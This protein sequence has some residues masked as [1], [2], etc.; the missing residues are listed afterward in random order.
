MSIV[1]PANEYVP[2]ALMFC[3]NTFDALSVT[4]IQPFK[5]NAE[6]KMLSVS[7]VPTWVVLNP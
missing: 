1:S 7:F 5:L 2:V 3:W 4:V 6:T